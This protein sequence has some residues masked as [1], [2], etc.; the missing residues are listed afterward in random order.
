MCVWS[1][2]CNVVSTLGLILQVHF[3]YRACSWFDYNIF[4]TVFQ[5]GFINFGLYFNKA[6]YSVVFLRVHLNLRKCNYVFLLRYY[7]TVEVVLCLKLHHIHILALFTS[8]MAAR[9]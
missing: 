8:V 1:P 4:I 7:E 9:C 3:R 5:K 2:C 6:R